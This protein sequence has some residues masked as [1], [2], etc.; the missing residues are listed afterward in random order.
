VDHSAGGSM[1]NVAKYVN[2]V[3][4]HNS[5]DALVFERTLRARNNFLALICVRVDLSINNV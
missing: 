3:D 2:R 1:K 5:A 4:V